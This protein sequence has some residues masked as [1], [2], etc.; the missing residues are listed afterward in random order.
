MDFNQL[1]QL[2]VAQYTAALSKD[3]HISYQIISESY[4]L[5]LNHMKLYNP[6]FLAYKYVSFK[7][8]YIEASWIKYKT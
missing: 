6:V 3:K 5:D 2:A 8:G 1:F 4:E 7:L